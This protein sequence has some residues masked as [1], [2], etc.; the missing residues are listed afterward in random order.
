MITTFRKSAARPRLAAYISILFIFIVLLPGCAGRPILVGQEE[1]IVVGAAQQ[2]SLVSSLAPSFALQSA[3]LPHN[4]I[5]RVEA[6][7]KDGRESVCVNADFPVIYVGSSH[8]STEKATYTNLIY[9]IHFSETP[10]A[11]V[12]FALSA[13]KNV[14]ILVILTLD[15]QH[16]TILVTTANTCGCYA[17]SIPTKSLAPDLYPDK[18]PLERLSVYGERLPAR[19]PLVKED[20]RIQVVVR[21]DVHRVMDVRVVSRDAL[22][23]EPAQEAEMLGLDS[24]KK[25]PL[26]ENAFTSFYYENWP[27]TGHVKGAIK[28]W[29]SLFLSLPSLDLFVGM[30]KEYSGDGLQRNPFYTSLKPWNRNASDLNDFPAYLHF[31]GW[32][33]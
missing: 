23:R 8:F 17:A 18:W 7:K 22:F 15:A 21:A 32:K 4:R 19:L 20:E 24:L 12:P 11:M 30:D 31:N 28:P 5:G 27:L 10:F 33:L 9:R 29:E 1:Q 3:Q 2:A 25:L 6:I 14:G 16:K 26:G 13:G